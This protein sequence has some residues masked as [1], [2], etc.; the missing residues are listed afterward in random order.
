MSTFEGFML[1]NLSETL[2]NKRRE[3]STKSHEITLMEFRD[4]SCDFVDRLISWER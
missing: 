3:R 1:S 4:G 2:P